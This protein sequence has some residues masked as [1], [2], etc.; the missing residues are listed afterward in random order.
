MTRL[1]RW[2]CSFLCRLWCISSFQILQTS[3][4]RTRW[5]QTASGLLVLSVFAGF[6]PYF[7][8]CRRRGSHLLHQ[9]TLSLRFLKVSSEANINLRFYKSDVEWVQ[10]QKNA[11]MKKKIQKITILRNRDCIL[12]LWLCV[13]IIIFIDYRGY[14]A[15][16]W[17]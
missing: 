16:L 12:N 3:S 4:P 8:I 13:I 7:P 6:W 2:L 10:I 9:R 17:T 1:W 15:I 11:I 5:D 14:G